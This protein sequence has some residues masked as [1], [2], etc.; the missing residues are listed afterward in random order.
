MGL[1]V[2]S[3]KN[4]FSYLLGFPKFSPP[5]EQSYLKET[6]IGHPNVNPVH[7]LCIFLTTFSSTNSKR[8]DDSVSPGLVITSTD[9]EAFFVPFSLLFPYILR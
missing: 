4:Y 5:L 2:Y 8:V 6:P 3:K 9:S 7:T 1:I